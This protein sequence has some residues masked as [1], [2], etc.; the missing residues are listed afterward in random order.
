MADKQKVFD[1]LSIE[2]IAPSLGYLFIYRG[3]QLNQHLRRR[4][5]NF[6]NISWG[7]SGIKRPNLFDLDANANFKK[8]L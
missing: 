2:F 3:K 4:N 6:F 8:P 7:N 5:C 1:D